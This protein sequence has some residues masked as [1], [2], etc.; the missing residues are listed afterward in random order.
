MLVEPGEVARV[1]RALT[2]F[3]LIESSRRSHP[4]LG[5]SNVFFCFD[6]VFLE[7]LWVADRAEAGRTEL[8]RQLI[9][10]VDGRMSGAMPFGI[11]FRTLEPGDAVP[12]QTWIFEPP[13]ELGFKPI[14]ISLSSRDR[15]Q[16]LM[17][18]AQRAA[19]PDAWTD[20]KAGVRQTPAGISE[21][22]ALHI[23]PPPHAQPSAD[24]H[25]LHA[26]GMIGFDTEA[27]GPRLR[28]TLTHA[29]GERREL[30][31]TSPMT[32]QQ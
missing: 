24:L 16:P 17:F 6:N 9:E 15:S 31:L 25:A 29:S 26:L 5:T 11:A 13:A 22:T 12:F 27:D 7:I 23:T 14:P 28:L 2:D 18:R 19:R 4:G 1:V 3:G 30:V 20:G 10:R 21:V 32:E 8:G